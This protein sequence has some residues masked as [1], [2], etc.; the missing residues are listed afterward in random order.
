MVQLAEWVLE[1]IVAEAQFN[2][3]GNDN[4][5]PL[6]N[7]SNIE[8]LIQGREH[9]AYVKNDAF[10]IGAY[11]D[12]VFGQCD[13]EELQLNLKS[14]LI[15]S[16]FEILSKVQEIEVASFIETEFLSF[17]DIIHVNVYLNLEQQKENSL[18]STS[19]ENIQQLMIETE[20]IHKKMIF[21]A[22]NQCLQDYR[23]Y[24]TKGQPMP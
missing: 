12:E 19:S 16:P 18:K 8:P 10:S 1:K 24:G 23:P 14:P 15:R 4:Y 20:H 5:I 17:P 9:V 3:L 7:I 2:S 13:L 6:L 22:I 11:V 21:D